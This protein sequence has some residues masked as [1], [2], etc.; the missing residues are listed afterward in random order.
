MFSIEPEFRRVGHEGHHTVHQLRHIW[1][2]KKSRNLQ[3]KV[4]R[5]RRNLDKFY[6]VS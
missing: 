3:A 1:Q 2:E 5:N 6:D 4:L